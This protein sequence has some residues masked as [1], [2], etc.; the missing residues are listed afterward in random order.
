LGEEGKVCWTDKNGHLRCGS[1]SPG[2]HSRTNARKKGG[3]WI[4]GVVT[5]LFGG[6]GETSQTMVTNV[7]FQQFLRLEE[8]PQGLQQPPEKN[9]KN[10]AKGRLGGKE[11][12]AKPKEIHK[13]GMVSGE[14]RVNRAKIVTKGG[15]GKG[16]LGGGEPKGG[17]GAIQ[18]WHSF[19]RPRWK[20]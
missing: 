18:Q 11:K 15:G 9:E 12:R 16:P 6:G 4:K 3:E 10:P 19:K 2:C 5:R 7:G 20:K 1:L 17:G 8:W 13:Q 14:K